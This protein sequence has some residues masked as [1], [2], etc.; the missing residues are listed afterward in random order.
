MG[1]KVLIFKRFVVVYFSCKQLFWCG[2]H[3]VS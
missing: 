1:E 3:A 2:L